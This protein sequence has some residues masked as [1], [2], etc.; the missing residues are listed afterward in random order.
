[1]TVNAFTFQE[2]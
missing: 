2:N 1:L